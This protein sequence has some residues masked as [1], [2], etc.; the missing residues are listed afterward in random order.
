MVC[1]TVVF[2][3]YCD[4]INAVKTFLRHMMHIQLILYVAQSPIAK[5][6]IYV[7]QSQ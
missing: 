4:I 7:N 3:K 5:L 1:Y 6:V 2:H